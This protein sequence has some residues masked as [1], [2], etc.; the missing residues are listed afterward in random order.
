MQ[1]FRLVIIIFGQIFASGWYKEKGVN[2]RNDC[3]FWGGKWPQVPTPQ[4][5]LMVETKNHRTLGRLLPNTPTPKT[6]L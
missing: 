5:F 3:F 4:G 2:D 1:M 6:S